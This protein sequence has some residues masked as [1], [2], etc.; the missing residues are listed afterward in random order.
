[1]VLPTALAD[2]TCAQ[3]MLLT[4]RSFWIEIKKLKNQSDSDDSLS[5]LDQRLNNKTNILKRKPAFLPAELQIHKEH[6]S[7]S[8]AI[9]Y[10]ESPAEHAAAADQLRA[11]IVEVEY[12]WRRNFHSGCAVDLNAKSESIWYPM[13]SAEHNCAWRWWNSQN[14]FE[15]RRSRYG[16]KKHRRT[17]RERDQG[18]RSYLWQIRIVRKHRICPLDIPCCEFNVYYFNFTLR[19]SSLTTIEMTAKTWGWLG[20]QFV[21]VYVGTVAGL[22]LITNVVLMPS[23]RVHLRCYLQTRDSKGAVVTLETILSPELLKIPTNDLFPTWNVILDC[24]FEGRTEDTH[25]AHCHS[26]PGRLTTVSDSIKGNTQPFA[27]CAFKPRRGNL[28]KHPFSWSPVSWQNQYDHFG[29]CYFGVFWKIWSKSDDFFQ[30]ICSS[31]IK[32]RNIQHEYT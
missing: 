18:I 10:L 3:T 20:N 6:K 29:F 2:L 9:S 13:K 21:T 8:A 22:N 30:T 32:D 24:S 5:D 15:R 26:G 4:R 1:M 12:C 19:H 17:E 28:C 23:Q 31:L 27:V 14:C 16:T 25:R 7:Y 11:G